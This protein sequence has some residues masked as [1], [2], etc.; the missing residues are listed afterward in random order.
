MIEVVQVFNALGDPVRLEMIRRLAQGHPATISEVSTGLGISR[1]GARKH[2]QVL[3][4]AQLVTLRPKGRDVYVAL[5]DRALD[6]ARNYILLLEKQWDTRLNSLK[7]FVESENQ[8]D[9]V[10][11]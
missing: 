7:Q 1:Q 5:E 9:P 4:D 10:T 6:Q 2:L 3:A 8:D 11:T